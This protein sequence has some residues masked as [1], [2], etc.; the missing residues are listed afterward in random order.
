MKILNVTS[1][2]ELRGGDAQMY[3]VYN[4]LK[5]NN[6]LT[7]YILCPENAALAEICKNDG[8]NFFT[9]KKNALKLLNLVTAIL[10]ICRREKIDII[11]IHDSTA[12]NAG[13]I[14]T[15][16]LKKTT[17][18][19][20]S[21]KRNNPIKD[22]FLNRYKY[23]HPKITKI[24][25]VSKAVE[26][27]FDNIIKDK[28]KLITIYDA[29]DVSFFVK[30]KSKNLIHKE[31]NLSVETKIVGNI[32]A[33]TGQKD[34]FTF[35]DTARKII[36]KK[37]QDINVK[38][39]VIGD[40]QQRKELNKHVISNN[41][42]DEIIFMGYRNNVQELLPE[43]DIFLSSS[44]TEGL[45]LTIY[46]AFASKVSVVTTNAGGIREIVKNGVTGYI[47]N[48][49]DSESLANGVLKLLNDK[50]ISN[51]IKENAFNLVSENHDLN[52]M[53]KN[54]YSFYS[55]LK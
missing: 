23:S 29:I 9:Y 27:I 10:K 15:H 2:T 26:A 32:S 21:R 3:T 51:T 20:L 43:F 1:I 35:I 16:F 44:L 49:R 55:S 4:L 28:S 19:V 54:Y 22:K 17:T 13:L 48:L 33:L 24:V 18:L 41:L 45:P 11:H 30:N 40:G 5:D 7:Q 12:L 36:D 50:E 6:D 31:F 38:F 52:S 53:K 47:S 46:E 37:P 34:I 42:Q 14:A 39:V 25:S 8:A